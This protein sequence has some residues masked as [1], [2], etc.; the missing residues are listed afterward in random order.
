[1][2]RILITWFDFLYTHRRAELI[3]AFRSTFT[4]TMPERFKKMYPGTKVLIDF[5]A[6]YPL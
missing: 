2:S 6:R 3:W 4:D 1:M 5:I